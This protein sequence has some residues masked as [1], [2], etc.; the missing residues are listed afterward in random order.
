MRRNLN[1]QRLVDA[2]LNAFLRSDRLQAS[3]V[4]ATTLIDHQILRGR[5]EAARVD[6]LHIALG[7]YGER[8]TVRTL[9]DVETD[10]S[11]QADGVRDG[12]GDQAC[13]EGGD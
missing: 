8:V 10:G 3:A 13:P 2:A 6:E 9:G 11:S 5:D 1:S 12:A 4:P 7:A